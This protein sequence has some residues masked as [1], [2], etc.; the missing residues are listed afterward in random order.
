MSILWYATSQP[1]L[2]WEIK[3]ALIR[4]RPMAKFIILDASPEDSSQASAWLQE[5]H[6]INN[7][8]DVEIILAAGG[9]A[10][11][12]RRLRKGIRYFD[13]VK[14]EVPRFGMTARLE[15]GVALLKL[16]FATPCGTES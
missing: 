10:V 11:A 8:S 13:Q 2:V 4:L 1:K 6:G 16:N 9:I 3:L 12:A 5:K 7:P 14:T 15:Q